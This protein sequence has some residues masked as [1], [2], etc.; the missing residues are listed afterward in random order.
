MK[1]D[2]TALKCYADLVYFFY[3]YILLVSYASVIF[4]KALTQLKYGKIIVIS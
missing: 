2:P 3:I 1:V 4:F